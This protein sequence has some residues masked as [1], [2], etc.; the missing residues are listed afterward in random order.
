MWIYYYFFFLFS[1]SIFYIEWDFFFFIEDVGKVEVNRVYKFIK[2]IRVRVD[3]EGF[4]VRCFL[5]K[6]S[7]FMLFII[8]FIGSYG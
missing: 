7:F 3:I 2:E 1:Y 8:N 5:K 4:Y 6:N